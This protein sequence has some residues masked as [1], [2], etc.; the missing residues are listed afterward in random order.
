MTLRVFAIAALITSFAIG[1]ESGPV[2]KVAYLHNQKIWIKE[3]PNGEP[4]QMSQGFA[5][6]PRWSPSGKWLS[7]VQNPNFFV[8]ST[9][10]GSTPVNFGPGEFR[11]SPTRDELAFVDEVGLNVRRFEGAPLQELVFQMPRGASI[12]SFD[13][14]FDGSALAVIVVQNGLSNL[15]ST[16]LGEKP[17]EVVHDINVR[18]S[19]AF[20][21]AHIGFSLAGSSSDGRYW[22]MWRHPSNSASLAADGLSMFSVNAVSGDIQLLMP[23]SALVHSDFFA[24]TSQRTD[25]LIVAGDN[26]ETWTNKRLTL[27]EP[28]TGKTVALTDTKAAVTTPAWSPDG[29]LIAYSA[30]T[31]I[32]SAGGGTPARNAVFERRLWLMNADGTG[33]HQLTSDT[34]Y[35][36]ESPHWTSDGRYILF[37]RMDN[38]NRTSL[39]AVQVDNGATQKLIDE[40]GGPADSG[41]WFGYYGHVDWARIFSAF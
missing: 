30:A 14:N 23:Q 28:S 6:F 31:D 24:R 27:A 22:L 20:R 33:T 2:A 25:L 10:G 9:E 39:W 19:R 7:F 5:E 32:G 21:L 35:R 40:I 18:Q 12:S 11:W 4:R 29:R 8:V 36:D 38:Q 1:Q 15:W 17:A 13:W 41:A 3:L 34:R 26:R 37:L 16:T